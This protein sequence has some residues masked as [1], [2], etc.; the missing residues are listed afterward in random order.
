MNSVIQIQAIQKSL[1]LEIIM[2]L[3]I[4]LL[5][6]QAN[7]EDNWHNKVSVLLGQKHLDKIILKI[8]AIQLLDYPLIFKRKTGQLVLLLILLEQV[9]NKL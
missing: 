7:A 9:K 3:L 4:I 8:I 1:T 2:F 6:T 5:N